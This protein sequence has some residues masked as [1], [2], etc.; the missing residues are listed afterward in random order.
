MSLY[1]ALDVSSIKVGLEGDSTEEIV[2]ELVELLVQSGKLS[3]RDEATQALLDREAKGP[4][5]IGGGQAIPHATLDSV[6]G[7]VVALGLSEEGVEFDSIDHKLVHVVVML[8]AKTGQPEQ[9]VQALRET[10]TLLSMPRFF[11][12]LIHCRTPQEAL[13]LIRAEEE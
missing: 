13:D 5:G 2:A 4:T 6:D 8:L 11:D 12:K 1:K 3:G 7:L 10:G 9:Y